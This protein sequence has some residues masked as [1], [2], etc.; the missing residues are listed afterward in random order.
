MVLAVLLTS[1][2]IGEIAYSAAGPAHNNPDP[3]LQTSIFP[4]LTGNVLLDSLR[5]AYAPDVV[6]SYDTARDYMFSDVENNSSIVEC[7]YTGKTVIIDPNEA[8]PTGYAYTN[9]NFNTEHIYPQSKGA[10]E[11]PARSDLH[12]LRAAYGNVN[13][14]RGNLPFGAL[15]PV[16]VN[17][18]WYYDS[19]SNTYSQDTTPDG[20]LGLWSRTGSTSFQPR[21]K[22]KGDVA[23]AAFYF[24]MMYESAAYEADPAFFTGMM[25]ELLSFHDADPIDATEVTR[26]NRINAIQGNLNPFITDTTL[27]RRAF[28]Q[29]FDPNEGSETDT[30][31]AINFDTET[32][33]SYTT[34]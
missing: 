12:H 24:Y 21:D 14:S 5:A 4:A 6:Y 15:D 3:V 27:I 32:K 16:D 33:T 23:R 34:G 13:S 19:E 1:L 7:I 20:D 8:D 17:R 18:W 25:D 10:S 9:F 30:E 31:L 22:N 29:D 26:N 2:C 11:S 28:F